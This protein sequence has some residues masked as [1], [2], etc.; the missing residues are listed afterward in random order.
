MLFFVSLLQDVAVASMGDGATTS[1]FGEILV[2]PSIRGMPRLWQLNCCKFSSYYGMCI[3]LRKA[4]MEWFGSTKQTGILWSRTVIKSL[5]VRVSSVVLRSNT[6]PHLIFFG[7]SRFPVRLRP[8]GGG[9]L[10]PNFLR[11]IFSLVEVFYLLQM[12]LVFPICVMENSVAFFVDL[13]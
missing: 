10:S 6:T 1:G 7:V 8:S 9:V 2:S 12:L 11:K 13:S 5:E 4:S 3:L